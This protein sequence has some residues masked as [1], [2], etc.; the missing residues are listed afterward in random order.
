VL[1]ALLIPLAGI[2]L[3]DARLD[4]AA[5]GRLALW[6]MV[7]LAYGACWFGLAVA[8]NA[9]G[10]PPAF[11]ALLLAAAWLLLVVLVPGLVNLAVASTY[12][13]PSRVEFVNATRVATDKARVEG[14]RLLTRFFE[15]HPTLE[16]TDEA[17]QNFDILQAA[18]DEEVA[19]QLEP[20]IARYNTQLAKQHAAVS[21]LRFFS[22]AAVAQS[23]LFDAAGT[24]LARYQ[25]FFAQVDTFHQRWK[26]FFEARGFAGATMRPEDFD[27]LPAFSYAEE[28]LQAV[29]NRTWLP[30]AVLWLLAI[31]VLTGALVTYR[32]YVVV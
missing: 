16:A 23:V 14:S 4:S 31:A 18:R 30:L 10:R 17:M 3:S 27:R 25:H 2:W 12:P 28:P 29:L 6:T 21:V 13:V 32:R 9:L 22:P 1:P 7:V 8:V 5:F 11:N 15:E 26:Q 24:S 19:R 20:V